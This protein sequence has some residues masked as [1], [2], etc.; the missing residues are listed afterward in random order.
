MTITITVKNPGQQS[1]S[2]PIAILA[3]GSIS[4]Y[5]NREACGDRLEGPAELWKK[6]VLHEFSLLMGLFF[7]EGGPFCMLLILGDVITTCG[8]T[9]FPKFCFLNVATTL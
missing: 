6:I 8:G 4:Y 7:G 2:Q 3:Q 9:V 1:H 5:A